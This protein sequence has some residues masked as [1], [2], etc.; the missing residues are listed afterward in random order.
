[1][2]QRVGEA[3][4]LPP[5]GLARI[6]A[7]LFAVAHAR[8]WIADQLPA[9]HARVASVQRVG[10]HPFERVAA[11]QLEEWRLLDGAEFRVLPGHGQCREVFQQTDALPIN[12]TGRGLRLIAMFRQGL[13]PWSLRV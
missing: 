3:H 8:A 9:D 13:Y 5:P 1:M 12:L 10:E 4:R 6:F 11:Q 2:A 7:D